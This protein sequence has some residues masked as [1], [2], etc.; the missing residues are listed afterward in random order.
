MMEL[1]CATEAA[2]RMLFWGGAFVG[3]L[4]MWL[5]CTVGYSLLMAVPRWVNRWR[6]VRY[7]LYGRQ[8]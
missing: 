5:T 3:A 2:Q 6:H 8:S 1:V 4:C 7:Q